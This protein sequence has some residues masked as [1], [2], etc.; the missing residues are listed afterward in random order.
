MAVFVEIWYRPRRGY[1]AATDPSRST[2]LEAGSP[3]TGKL[4]GQDRPVTVDRAARIAISIAAVGTL[5]A[6]EA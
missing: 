3:M 2:L 1:A 6:T 4:D 5:C